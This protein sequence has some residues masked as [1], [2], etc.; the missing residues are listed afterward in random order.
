MSFGVL[1]YPNF[2]LN[3]LRFSR[4]SG[5]SI[6]FV[7]LKCRSYSFLLHVD[8]F[9]FMIVYLSFVSV[10][11]TFVSFSYSFAVRFYSLKVSFLTSLH[12]LRLTQNTIDNSETGSYHWTGVPPS[13]SLSVSLPVSSSD[14]PSHPHPPPLA[15]P[16]LQSGV[17]QLQW[18]F[19]LLTCC[20]KPYP[21]GSYLYLCGLL[22]GLKWSLLMEWYGNFYPVIVQILAYI[23]TYAP[24]YILYI[25]YSYTAYRVWCVCGG[26]MCISVFVFVSVL[27]F[28]LI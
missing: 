11:S 2:H 1:S 12:H 19:G 10:F 18:I 9:V 24:M 27:L 5:I 8:W 26:C 16:L 23:Y 25:G 17:G 3:G 6:A 15:L 13:A 21:D 20:L 7:I 28:T 4:P 14:P 22:V